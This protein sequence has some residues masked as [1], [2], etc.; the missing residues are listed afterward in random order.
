MTSYIWKKNLYLFK[1][2]PGLRYSSKCSHSSMTLHKSIYPVKFLSFQIC[3]TGV[4]YW[5]IIKSK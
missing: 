2:Q 5:Y 3:K 1:T 4:M